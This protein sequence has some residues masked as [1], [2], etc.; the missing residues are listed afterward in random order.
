MFT[1]AVTFLKNVQRVD[2]GW[3]EDNYS[4]HDTAFSGKYHF[5]TAF[6]TAW[7]ILALCAAVEGKST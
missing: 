3:G 4:Y 7:A 1:K 2:G 6:Q 5:S